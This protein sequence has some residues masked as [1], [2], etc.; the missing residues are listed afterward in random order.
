MPTSN[1]GRAGQGLDYLSQVAGYESKIKELREEVDDLTR[2]NLRLVRNREENKRCHRDLIEVRKDN[3]K[4][5]TEAAAKKD[6][7]DQLQREITQLQAA[8]ERDIAQLRSQ[9][10]SE[11]A[12]LEERLAAAAAAKEHIVEQKD[13]EISN[14]QQQLQK[15]NTSKQIHIQQQVEEAV[16][17]NDVESGSDKSDDDTIDGNERNTRQS[18]AKKPVKKRKQSKAKSHFKDWGPFLNE[19]NFDRHFDEALKCLKAPKSVDKNT[20]IGAT[21]LYDALSFGL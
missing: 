3:A 13:A 10:I 21:H 17:P 11:I 14:L 8:K 12:H 16:F 4:L 19:E 18:A 15:H 1:T 20:F 5:A 9:I 2:K 6:K 7:I